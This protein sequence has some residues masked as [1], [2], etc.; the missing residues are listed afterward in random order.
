MSKR[1]KLIIGAA[2]GALAAVGGFLFYKSRKKENKGTTRSGVLFTEN[3][4]D[5]F[6]FWECDLITNACKA[7]TRETGDEG[8]FT[9]DLS[10][11]CVDDIEETDDYVIVHSASKKDY[12][13][14]LSRELSIS[15]YQVI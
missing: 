13:I 11:S 15:K 6:D 7:I 5:Y 8:P 12:K 4:E 14:D 9:V 10:L 3:I 2:C 1:V